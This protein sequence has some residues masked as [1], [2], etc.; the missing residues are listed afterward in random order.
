MT[1]RTI[2]ETMGGHDI[3]HL[4]QLEAIVKRFSPEQSAL[5]ASS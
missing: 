1:F 5:S 4:R 3:N 2:V